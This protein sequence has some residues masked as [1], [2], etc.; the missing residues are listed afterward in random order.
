MRISDWSSDVCSSDL[1]SPKTNAKLASASSGVAKKSLHMQGMAIDINLSDKKLTKIRDA[2]IGM[3][4]G[5]VGYYA[6]SG[7]VPV[8]T[9]SE[10]RRVGNEGVSTGRSRWT[11]VN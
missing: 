4:R 6:Q 10:E 1:R 5:G 8:D 9:R 11:P 3:R 2:A 7:F